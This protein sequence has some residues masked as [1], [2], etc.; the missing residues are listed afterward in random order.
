MSKGNNV[1]VVGGGASGLLA[2]IAASRAG[3]TVTVLERLERVGKKL[4]VT[5]NG[6]C[7]LTNL[8][9]SFSHFHG[10]H[11]EF[12]RPTLTALDAKRTREFFEELGIT[13]KVEEGG[14]VY[15][16]CE[17]ASA[18]LDVLRYEL[19]RQG[20]GVKPA[21]DVVRIRKDKNGFRLALKGGESLRSERVILATGGKASP[22]LGSNGSGYGLAEALGH[23]LVEPFPALVQLRLEAPFL[24]QLKG[25]KI[26]GRAALLGDEGIL[27]QEEGEI[28]FA[29]YGL[30]GPPVL[31]L[32]RRAGERLQAGRSVWLEL[33]LFPT[34]GC[35]E[36]VLLLR[37]RL[38]ALPDRSVGFGLVGFLHKRLI[39]VLL[40]QVGIGA[41]RSSASVS[42]S[43]IERV[44]AQAEGVAAGRARAPF[45]GA[46]P[47]D[48]RR[49]GHGRCRCAHSGVAAGA[50][51]PFLRRTAGHRRRQRW[52]QPAVGLVFRF[53]GGDPFGASLN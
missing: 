41:G 48:G 12:A 3:A 9:G 46:G 21:A 10:R 4:L 8:D 11:P 15:P 36:L 19:Q 47:G 25:L 5:G 50:G 33:D 49:R 1:A 42:G 30:S 27:Q 18:V 28:L 44:A 20:V 23:G 17:Q 52:L 26:V 14:K 24:K 22:Q 7:N 13:T 16:L 40:Q 43:E 35:P 2:A 45:L 37:R 6:R 53:R 31:Q 34:C 38:A 51:S 29:D 32:S 39:P